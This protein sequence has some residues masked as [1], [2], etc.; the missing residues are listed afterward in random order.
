MLVSLHLF[1]FSY[2]LKFVFRPPGSVGPIA[3]ALLIHSWSSAA[4]SVRGIRMRVLAMSFVSLR[5]T[6][7]GA[8]HIGSLG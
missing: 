8:G 4:A 7:L 6:S 5:L 1:A 3:S 2:P